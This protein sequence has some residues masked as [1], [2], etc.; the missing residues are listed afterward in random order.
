MTQPALYDQDVK[1]LFDEARLLNER[2]RVDELLIEI[3]ARYVDLAKGYDA[4]VLALRETRADVQALRAQ[5]AREL[6]E[7]VR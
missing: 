1:A 2:P 6:S 5:L 4:A 7:P 3:E